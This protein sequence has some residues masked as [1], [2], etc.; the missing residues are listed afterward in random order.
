MQRASCP[1]EQSARLRE[2]ASTQPLKA[3]VSNTLHLGRNQ[4]HRP[5]PHRRASGF[6]ASFD[7]VLQSNAREK[8]PPARRYGWCLGLA[9]SEDVFGC[10]KALPRK[11]WIAIPRPSDGAAL[12]NETDKVACWY[13]GRGTN[14]IACYRSS[15]ARV[16]R[17]IHARRNRQNFFVC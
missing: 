4:G 11:G 5:P 15:L 9:V 12:D 3:T 2:R 1:A 17:L 16:A 10:H 6:A 8:R 14:P 7:S 13:D